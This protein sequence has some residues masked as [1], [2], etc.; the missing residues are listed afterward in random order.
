MTTSIA[1]SLPDRQLNENKIHTYARSLHTHMGPKAEVIAAQKI[2][3]YEAVEDAVKLIEWQR[4]RSALI[5]MNGRK[6]H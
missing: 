6:L 2:T 1:K 3:H 5:M 4:I